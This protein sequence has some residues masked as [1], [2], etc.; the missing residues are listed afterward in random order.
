[1]SWHGP[2]APRVEGIATKSRV[3]LSCASNPASTASRI[4]GVVSATF[5]M[6]YFPVIHAVATPRRGDQ[7][8][9]CAALQ[10]SRTAFRIG[11]TSIQSPMRA[12]LGPSVERTRRM[13]REDTRQPQYPLSDH[14]RVDHRGRRAW[15]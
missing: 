3:A 6:S 11:P 4:L 7:I 12:A 10:P 1:M 9:L 5:I 8:I 14:R 15:L 13:E 2:S